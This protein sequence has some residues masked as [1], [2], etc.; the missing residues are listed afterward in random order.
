M[1]DLLS[2]L[3]QFG[4][5]LFV[6]KVNSSHTLQAYDELGIG[7]M[8]SVVRISKG[9]YEVMKMSPSQRTKVCGHLNLWFLPVYR[10]V[11]CKIYIHF[12]VWILNTP[13]LSGRAHLQ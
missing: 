2:D 10:K 13:G 12:W 1:L 11:H 8:K 9:R 7:E 5:G 6:N 4:F 3:S